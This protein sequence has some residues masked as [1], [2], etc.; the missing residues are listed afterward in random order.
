[1]LKMKR[2]QGGYRKQIATPK[3][4]P[5]REPKTPTH[6]S[7]QYLYR[8]PKRASQIAQRINRMLLSQ[9]TIETIAYVEDI[10]Q[11]QVMAQMTKWDLPRV[12]KK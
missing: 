5:K 2:E 11:T 10:S 6:V 9:M 1:M 4:K 3:P 7:D 8:W 12:E